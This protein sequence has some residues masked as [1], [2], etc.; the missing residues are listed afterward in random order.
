MKLYLNELAPWERKKEYFQHIQLG[1]DLNSQA[2][3]L[4]QAIDNQ[5]R[6]NLA[7]ASAIIASQERI[8]EGI[9][10][11]NVK[12]EEGLNGLAN[13]FEWG[14]AEVVWQLEQNREVLTNILAV[15]M[16]PLDTHAKERRKRAEK[17]FENGWIDDADEEFLESEKLNKYDFAI[18][19]SLGVIYL[20]HKI[21]KT[22]ALDYFDKAIKYA[23]PESQYH[24]SY[25]LLHKAL[26]KRD[27]GKMDDA[28]EHSIEAIQLC[29]S[30]NEA[31]YQAAVYATATN[32]KNKAIEYLKKLIDTDYSYCL[33]I[34]NDEDFDAI[35]EEINELFAE[36][37]NKEL[38]HAKSLEKSLTSKLRQINS[39][40]KKIDDQGEIQ[41]VNEMPPEIEEINKVLK[42]DSLFDA[43]SAQEMVTKLI[44]LPQNIAFE[45]QLEV[46]RIESKI[47]RP[48]QEDREKSDKIVSG[49][50][51]NGFIGCFGILATIVLCTAFGGMVGGVFGG[52]IGFV[53]GCFV[54]SKVEDLFLYLGFHYDERPLELPLGEQKRLSALNTA[55]SSLQSIKES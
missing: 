37:K 55:V 36:Y 6:A 26:I 8:S 10:D 25:A 53:V 18:H 38:L 48:F 43:L 45:K 27:M 11:L 17:A 52:I 46:H 51:R 54:Q 14:I 39:I 31:Y 44:D 28:Y 19:I 24:T 7:S 12:I 4:R 42:R 5:S 22:K 2:H 33:K 50:F 21:D 40:L 20:F 35:K 16:A 47:R 29:P 13:V 1:K 23:R 32:R 49:I 15:L 34:D 3:A 9:Q 41:L 30:F